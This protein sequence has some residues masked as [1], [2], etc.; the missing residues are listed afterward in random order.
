M[1][2]NQVAM[3]IEN[4]RLVAVAATVQG[5]RVIVRKWL[6]AARPA[7]LDLTNASAVGR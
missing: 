6:T 1:E 7:D 4:D 2:R 5:D 3:N